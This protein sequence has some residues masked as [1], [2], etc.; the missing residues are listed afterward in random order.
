M[1]KLM[2]SLVLV[3]ALASVA[4][5]SVDIWIDDVVGERGEVV[6]VPIMSDGI[7]GYEIMGYRIDVHFDAEMVDFVD[8]TFNGDQFPDENWNKDYSMLADG[9]VRVW[10]YGLNT[11]LVDVPSLFTVRLKVPNDAP[12]GDCWDFRFSDA[13]F[14]DG[15]I[16]VTADAGTFCTPDPDYGFID[17]Y[18]HY[19][20]N[21]DYC[22]KNGAEGVE[23]TVT[24]RVSP[25]NVFGTDETDDSGAFQVQ[26]NDEGLKRTVVEVERPFDEGGVDNPVVQFLNYKDQRIFDEYALGNNETLTSCP[27]VVVG[28]CSSDLHY[29]QQ[30]AADLD[31]DGVL[32]PADAHLLWRVVAS[33][34]PLSASTSLAVDYEWSLFCEQQD[35]DL[36]VLHGEV[37]TV[38]ANFVGLIKGDVNGDYPYREEAVG[39]KSMATLVAPRIS[40]ASDTETLTVALNG[41]AEFDGGQFAMSFDPSVISLTNVRLA[42]DLVGFRLHKTV[43][44][45]LLLV[46]VYSLDESVVSDTIELVKFDAVFNST[47]M[48]ARSD[49][50]FES[51][52]VGD[53]R[54]VFESGFITRDIVAN[55]V[56]SFSD[57]KTNFR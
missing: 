37:M 21:N 30:I 33:A 45:G 47:D 28:D 49:F 11:A 53:G 17:G 42:D 55:E 31:K 50:V 16:P 19:F 51:A 1:Q 5:A 4:S 39:L 23:V 38:S 44:N 29:P 8:L 57:L 26:L 10:V 14:N 43:Q 36:T 48:S 54:P 52:V 24:N 9:L 32:T 41:A 2:V 35:V 40:G 3:M 27:F 13:T 46:S 7:G 34:M 20:T 25:Y 56:M 6:S 22:G 18:V 12:L 15:T